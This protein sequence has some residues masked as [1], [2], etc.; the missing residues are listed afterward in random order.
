MNVLERRGLI[1]KAAVLDEIRRLRAQ[2][3]EAK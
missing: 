2:A 3:P 1:T